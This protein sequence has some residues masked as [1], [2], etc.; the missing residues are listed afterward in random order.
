MKFNKQE[1]QH[2]NLLGFHKIVQACSHL[3][4]HRNLDRRAYF[5]TINLRNS[6]KKDV[7]QAIY[8]QICGT[9]M[10]NGHISDSITPGL[11][12]EHDREGSRRGR[13]TNKLPHFHGLLFSTKEVPF[14]RRWQIRNLIDTSLRKLPDVES[15]L[16][17]VY[18]YRETLGYVADY[19][20]KLSKLKSERGIPDQLQGHIYP[21]DKVRVAGRAGVTKRHFWMDRS[22]DRLRL[23]YE[24]PTQF[25]SPEY[26]DTFG[27]EIAALFELGRKQELYPNAMAA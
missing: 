12:L 27:E 18:D 24:D 9:L 6:W 16:T 26:C 17:N 3:D 15:S 4:D 1:N 7:S 21:I 2:N 13:I 22:D 11:V 14:H 19:N 23:L 8:R 5:L 25:F 20:T 10:E